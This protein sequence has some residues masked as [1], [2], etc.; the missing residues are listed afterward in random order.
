MAL[1]ATALCLIGR[2][3]WQA[4][5]LGLT[6]GVIGIVGA[7]LFARWLGD[8]LYL[9]AQQHSGM[10]FNVTTTDPPSLLGGLVG[11]LALALLAGAIPARRVSRID[12]VRALRAE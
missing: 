1:G 10:L 2:A 5:R 8:S 11:V 3:L 7:L 9:V 6:G 12:P 4:A